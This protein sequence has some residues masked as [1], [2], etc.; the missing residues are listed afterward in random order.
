MDLSKIYN[1]TVLY[2]GNKMAFETPLAP[3]GLHFSFGPSGVKSNSTD[4]AVK[5]VGDLSDNLFYRSVIVNGAK[6]WTRCHQFK[7]LS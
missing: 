1:H 5:N 4:L 2:P 3:G 7:H 6:T